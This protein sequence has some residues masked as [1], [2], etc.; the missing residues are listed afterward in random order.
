MHVALRVSSFLFVQYDDRDRWFF[1]F[2]VMKQLCT[3]V[4]QAGTANIV[5]RRSLFIHKW[6]HFKRWQDFDRD[7]KQNEDELQRVK[8]FMRI[9]DELYISPEKVEDGMLR[10]WTFC[11]IIYFSVTE[12]AVG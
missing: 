10:F 4:C 3:A 5:V 9:N 2:I 1:L 12:K 6:R 11:V 7:T 8:N